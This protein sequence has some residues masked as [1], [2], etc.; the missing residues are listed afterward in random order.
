MDNNVE[1]AKETGFSLTKFGRIRMVP[2]LSSS[3]YQTRTFGERVA[4]NMPLQG[5]A[6]DI[7]KLAMLKVDK[8]LQE[9]GL[10]SQLILQIHDELI[11][12]TFPGEEIQVSNILKEE[13]ENVVS[14]KVPL[15]VTIGVGNNLYECK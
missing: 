9:E 11:I 8:K 6:S 13:M 7:I 10:K 4:M 15:S 14:L 5:T 12:D 2:E 3:K 1:S